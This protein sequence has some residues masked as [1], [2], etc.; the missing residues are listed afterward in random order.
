MVDQSPESILALRSLWAL[1][2]TQR[3]AALASI[4]RDGPEASWVAYTVDEQHTAAIL[5]LSRLAAHTRNLE[6][7]PRA[8]LAICEPDRSGVDPQQLV[9][10]SFHGVVEFID[11]GTADY[12]FACSIYQSHLPDSTRQFGFSDFRLLRLRPHTAR[13]VGGFGQV[14]SFD[15]EQIRQARRG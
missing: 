6:R 9:R 15:P 8:S 7:D 5:H 14:Y 11:P 4:G 3:W 10:V 1:L 2:R 12:D 13:F